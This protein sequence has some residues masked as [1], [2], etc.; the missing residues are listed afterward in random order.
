[1]L[2][3]VHRAGARPGRRSRPPQRRRGLLPLR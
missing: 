1:V 2:P 3:H